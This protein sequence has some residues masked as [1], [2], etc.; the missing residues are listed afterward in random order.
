MAQQ[1]ALNAQILR[2]EQ[3]QEALKRIQQFVDDHG[4]VSPDDV[5]WSHVGTMAEVAAKLDE[6]VKFLDGDE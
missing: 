3:A 4:E 2:T 1:T 5:N 6:L